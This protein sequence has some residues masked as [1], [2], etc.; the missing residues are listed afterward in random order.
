[1]KVMMPKIMSNS[2]T[3]TTMMN[4]IATVTVIVLISTA[5]VSCLS[6]EESTTTAT[7]KTTTTGTT[8][9]LLDDIDDDRFLETAVLSSVDA[10]T[11]N[12]LC[13]S[14]EIQSTNPVLCRMLTRLEKEP[15]KL[16]EDITAWAKRHGL[17]VGENLFV[18]NNVKSVSSSFSVPAERGDGQDDLTVNTGPQLPVVFAHGMGDSCFNS[19]MIHITNHTSSLLGNVYATCIAIGDNQAEDTVSL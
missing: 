15:E 2:N 4:L 14:D 8:R 12:S 9:S 11:Y 5:L 6:T 18:G 16:S 7:T 1:M 3:S 10:D 17:L 13:I 19:G